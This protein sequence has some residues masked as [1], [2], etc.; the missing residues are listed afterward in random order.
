MNPSS[1][2]WSGAEEDGGGGPGEAKE[3]EAE[4]EVGGRTVMLPWADV[5][6]EWGRSRFV[7]MEETMQAGSIAAFC[8]PLSFVMLLLVL[9]W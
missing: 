8:R 9:G 5:V 2:D 6:G 7:G 1:P 4:V 3:A